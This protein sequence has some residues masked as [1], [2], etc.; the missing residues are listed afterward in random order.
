MDPLS[1][2]HELQRALRSSFQGK[3]QKRSPL[4]FNHVSDGLTSGCDYKN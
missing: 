2:A 4:S 3:E 1:E